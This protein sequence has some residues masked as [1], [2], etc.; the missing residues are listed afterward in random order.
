MYSSTT[1]DTTFIRLS[2]LRWTALNCGSLG[3][4]DV[5]VSPD[6]HVGS[7]VHVSSDIRVD[8]HARVHPDIHVSSHVCVHP[9][10]R[11]QNRCT[12]TKL[13]YM[14]KIDVQTYTQSQRQHDAFFTFQICLPKLLKT[15]LQNCFQKPK[16]QMIRSIIF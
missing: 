9:D 1:K 10:V 5:H 7:D 16:C 2:R 14:Y 11:V 6:E 12:R 8:P 15:K 3:S 4:S 13:T